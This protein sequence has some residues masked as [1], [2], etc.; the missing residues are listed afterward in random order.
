MKLG[1][2]GHVGEN[3]VKSYYKSLSSSRKSFDEDQHTN[4]PAG[5]LVRLPGSLT[6]NLYH[7]QYGLK[8]AN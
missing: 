7:C 6:L 5:C 2:L 3:Q 1:W 4:L 8:V